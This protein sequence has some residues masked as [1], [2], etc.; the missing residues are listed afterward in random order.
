MD[1]RLLDLLMAERQQLAEDRR[2]F[3]RDK[4]RFERW[5]SFVIDRTS[6]ANANGQSNGHAANGGHNGGNSNG[7]AVATSTGRQ[8]FGRIVDGKATVLWENAEH[9]QE[10]ATNGAS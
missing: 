1:E 9:V 3:E 10:R 6:G 4:E 7:A 5:L 2:A 8:A